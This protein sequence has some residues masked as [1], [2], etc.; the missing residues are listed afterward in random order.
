MSVCC[1][2]SKQE[3]NLMDRQSA[4]NDKTPTG[5]TDTKDLQH[6]TNSITTDFRDVS[7]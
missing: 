6:G 2:D 1:H 4:R 3:Q 7:I 5:C